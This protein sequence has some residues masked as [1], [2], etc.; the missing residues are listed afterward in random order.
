M[1]RVYDLQQWRKRERIAHLQAEPL[2]RMCRAEG[3]LTPAHHCDHITPISQGGDPWGP[4]QS[5]C[6]RHHSQKTAKENGKQVKMGC[7][8]NGIPLDSEHHW[9]RKD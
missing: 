9:A 4:L 8:I 6:A 3:K 5:L 2:C 7:D 1:G